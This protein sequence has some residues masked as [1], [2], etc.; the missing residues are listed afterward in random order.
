MIKKWVALLCALMM[1]FALAACGEKNGADQTSGDKEDETVS[2]VDSMTAAEEAFSKAFEAD[3]AYDIDAMASVEYTVNFGADIDKDAVVKTANDAKAA[4]DEEELEEYKEG[5]KDL[6]YRILEK[7][8][9]S[10]D[11]LSARI[12][13]LAEK[14]RDTDKITEIIK[15]KYTID[16]DTLTDAQVEKDVEMICVDGAWYCYMG[17]EL[18]NQ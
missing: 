13:E 17:D 8:T 4:L 11:E 1:V 6:K 2:Q 15:L 3:K 9:L 12:A 16:S 7:T 5:L 14:F 18:W 10:A